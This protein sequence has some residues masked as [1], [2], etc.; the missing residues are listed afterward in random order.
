M[1]RPKVFVSRG[2]HPSVLARLGQV[3]D[4]SSWPGPDRCPANVLEREGV[5]A[6]AVL[7]TD[8]WTATMLDKATRLRL[9]ALTSVGFDMVD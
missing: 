8:R 6:D 3:C 7:G 5:E 9:I 4:T 2:V 1:S